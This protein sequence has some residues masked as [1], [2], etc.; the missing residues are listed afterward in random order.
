MQ[1]FHRHGFAHAA[2]IGDLQ[3]GTAGVQ[4]RPDPST[5]L[6]PGYMHSHLAMFDEGAIS[7]ITPWAFEKFTV[8]GNQSQYHGRA[9]GL[10]VLPAKWA[11]E[12]IG[13][14]LSDASITN[15]PAGPEQSRK[16]V[17]FVERRMGIPV[18]CWSAKSTKLL[19]VFIDKPRD[20]NLRFVT[21]REEG[22]N[23]EWRPGGYTLGGV[24]EAMI[25]KAGLEDGLA[26]PF[27]AL[28]EVLTDRALR[29]GGEI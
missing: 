26:I 28:F 24:P 10:F 21:G 13:Q 25:D 3:Q 20:L 5:Y 15:L 1:T 27:N 12:V 11:K 23:A 8:D 22:A 29:P 4:L 18:G 9:E 17:E 6:D 19:A 2:V 14:G 7:F 16:L